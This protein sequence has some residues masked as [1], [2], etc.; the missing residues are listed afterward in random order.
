MVKGICMSNRVVGLLTLEQW[1]IVFEREK[2]RLPKSD[3]ELMNFI[4]CKRKRVNLK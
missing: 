2:N 3:K 1:K 4:A